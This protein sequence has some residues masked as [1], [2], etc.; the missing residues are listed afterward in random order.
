MAILDQLKQLSAAEDFFAALDVAYE[1]ERL[2]VIR[3]HVLRR[4]GDYLRQQ[5]FAGQDD[6]AVRET[7]RQ[8]LSRAYDDLIQSG[9]LEQRVFKVLKDAVKPAEPAP[10]RNFVPLESLTMFG[11]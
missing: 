5:D 10:R 6:A 8:F 4:M 3:L 1:P 11:Q 2:R 9:P 7:C